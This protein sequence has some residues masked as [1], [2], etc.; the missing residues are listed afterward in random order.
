MIIMNNITA[1]TCILSATVIEAQKLA[2]VSVM[3]L[4]CYEK[5]QAREIGKQFA[6]L[7]FIYKY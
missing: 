6:K 7:R 2:T 5:L 3:I 4:V 1:G